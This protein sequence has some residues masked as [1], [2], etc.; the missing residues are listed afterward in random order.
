MTEPWHGM[1][2]SRLAPRLARREVSPV[3]VTA[4]LLQRIR[5]RDGELH[6]YLLLDEAGAMAQ[7]REAEARLG[8]G[9]GSPL[10]GI[11]L[12]LKDVMVTRGLRTTCAS[13]ILG[14]DR[15]STRLNSSHMVQSRMP[16]S[17]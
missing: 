1:S 9:E 5:E 3:E 16:S 14:K 12:A 13:K 8:R 4:Q 10:T 7:A 17:A 2:I 11:P 6:A 15:K